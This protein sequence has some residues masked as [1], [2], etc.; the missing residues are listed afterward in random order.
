[1]WET[2]EA[3]A[4]REPGRCLKGGAVGGAK[5]RRCPEEESRVEGS[6]G[7]AG[8]KGSPGGKIE[9]RPE[10]SGKGA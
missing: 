8:L 7:E 2:A 4:E 10:E 5:G 1:M 9:A 3:L 6:S